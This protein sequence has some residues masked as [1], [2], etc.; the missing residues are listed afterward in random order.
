MF[1]SSSCSLALASFG[2]LT[3]VVCKTNPLILNDSITLAV[4][5][6]VTSLEEALEQLKGWLA[7]GTFTHVLPELKVEVHIPVANVRLWCRLASDVLKEAK[8]HMA[9]R[10]HSSLGDLAEQVKSH[11]PPWQHIIGDTAYFQSMAKTQVLNYSGHLILQK[12]AQAMHASIKSLGGVLDKWGLKGLLKQDDLWRATEKQHDAVY[13]EAKLFLRVRAAC[14]VVQ[15]LK[16]KEQCNAA[17]ALMPKKDSLP[18]ALRKALEAVSSNKGRSGDQCFKRKY[19]GAAEGD[20]APDASGSRA[21]PSRK[22][23]KA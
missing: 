23:K 10:A 22:L 7:H 12:E 8:M 18:R 20:V 16:G 3:T 1:L 19:D 9:Q 21:K 13:D 6:A 14:N 4:R 17:D 11:I 5:G 15:V 2:Y